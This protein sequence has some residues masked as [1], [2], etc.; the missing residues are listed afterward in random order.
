M[1][2]KTINMRRTGMKPPEGS[3]RIDR[4]SKWGNPFRIRVDGN[5]QTVIQKYRD[6]IPNQP[7]L[8]KSIHELRGKDLACWCSPFPCHGD[9]LLEMANPPD[10][11]FDFYD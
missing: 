2:P 5:R 3:V 10:D 7:E 11:D 9:V 1:T 4:Q 8:M 6:W